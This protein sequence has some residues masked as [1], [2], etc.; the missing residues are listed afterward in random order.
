MRADASADCRQRVLLLDELEGLHVFAL[1]SQ[2]YISLD[3]DMSRA[4]SLARCRTCLDHVLSVV[5][6][7]GIVSFRTPLDLVRKLYLLMYDRCL[8]AD[9]LSES[10]GVVCA[11]LYALS[12]GNA[13]RGVDLCHIV[14]S[15]HVRST[16][17]CGA[18]DGHA[19]LRLAVADS[20]RDTALKSRYLMDAAHCL[21][22]FKMFI[23]LFLGKLLSAAVADHRLS[24]KAHVDAHSVFK[25]ACTFAH[26]A[27]NSAALAR[28]SAESSADRS[29]DK[30][31]QSLHRHDLCS[32]RQ[33]ALYRNDS[34]DTDA[35]RHRSRHL[36]I[37]L[38]SVSLEEIRDLRMRF[39][40]FFASG[41]LELEDSR[42]ERNEQVD[43]CAALSELYIHEVRLVCAALKNVFYF[44]DRHSRLLCQTFCRGRHYELHLAHNSQFVVSQQIIEQLILGAVRSDLQLSLIRHLSCKPD[45]L[46]LSCFHFLLPL[47]TQKR[48]IYILFKL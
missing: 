33:S 39:I 1:S 9:L 36:A 27:A 48:N 10:E 5:S 16:V 37:G 6:V 17:I 8:R 38:E 35:H 14:A 15:N 26:D 44:F 7:V 2:S 11:C 42:R 31:A 24:K 41:Q 19:A 12:A 21:R 3:S 13:L 34:H 47:N 22:S 43:L 45:K 46:V 23:D 25:I 28:N 30:S 4:C 29:L 20:E 40:V 32:C 18:S